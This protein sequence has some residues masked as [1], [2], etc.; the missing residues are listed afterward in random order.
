MFKSDYY[1]KYSELKQR[2]DDLEFGLDDLEQYG[3]RTSLRFHNVPVDQIQNGD[4]DSTVFKI[5]SD[6][7]ITITSDDINRSHPIGRKTRNNRVQ[8]IC[9]FRKWKIKNKIYRAKKQLKNNRDKIFVTKDLTKYRQK[10]VAEI[11]QAKNS[12]AEYTSS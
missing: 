1:K 11:I 9:R 10:I 2:V 8:I 6:M 7:E 5:C 4:T 3:R 12:M